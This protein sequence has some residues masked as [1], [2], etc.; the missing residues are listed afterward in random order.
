MPAVRPYVLTIAGFDP[1]GGAGLISDIKTLEMNRVYGLAVCSALTYQNHEIFTDAEWLPAEKII[2]QIK[3]LGDKYDF[4]IVKIGL[5]DITNALLP[6]ILYLTEQNKD[7]R[8]IWDPV[9]S[10][11][12]GFTF[13]NNISDSL[14]REVA[15]KAYLIT[16]NI[17]EA[18]VLTDN[19]GNPEQEFI[20]MTGNSNC[21]I[22]LKGGHLKGN[23]KDDILFTSGDE[24]TIGG[25]SIEGY[26]KHGTGCVLSSAIAAGL[27]LGRPLERACRDAKE[28]T[29]KFIL[30]NKTLLGYHYE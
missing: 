13:N 28:Y 3:V 19:K 11:S 10:S 7:I 23:T 8:I 14:L 26:S 2:R 5:I 6:V 27:A 21:S 9:L 30:S 20:T 24:I 25:K 1:S 22:L 29:R 12:S 4:Q 17:D 16:P 18:K 15:G